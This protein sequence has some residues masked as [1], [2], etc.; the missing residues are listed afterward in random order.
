MSAPRHIDKLG[1]YVPLDSRREEVFSPLA[2]DISASGPHD[3]PRITPEQMNLLR[4][5]VVANLGYRIHGL[6]NSPR[7]LQHNNQ[8]SR[9]PPTRLS[10]SDA[11]PVHPVYHQ[12]CNLPPA[13]QFPPSYSLPHAHPVQ[14]YPVAQRPPP[15]PPWL[16]P[17]QLPPLEAAP[18]L[19]LSHRNSWSTTS[20][21]LTQLPALRPS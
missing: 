17:L 9:P 18:S 11:W 19:S 2:Y 6:L 16:P 1:A 10:S 20:T 7:M 4:S 14:S 8:A 5:A 15:P 21:H 3:L 13:P 12:H